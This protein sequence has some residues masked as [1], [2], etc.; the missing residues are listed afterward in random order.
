MLMAG[1]G[2]S[3]AQDSVGMK[4]FLSSFGFYF[5]SCLNEKVE[6]RKRMT[7]LSGAVGTQLLPLC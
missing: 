7:R 3:A 1:Q 6:I 5:K 2:I 4:G